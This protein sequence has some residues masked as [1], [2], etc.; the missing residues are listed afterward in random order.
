MNNEFET[1]QNQWK[2]DKGNIESTSNDAEEIFSSI[3][4]KKSWSTRFHYGNILVLSTVLIGI[5]A[6]FY[7]VAPVQELLSRVGVGL[8]VGGLLIRIIIEV[9]SVSKAKKINMVNDALQTTND[10]ITFYN[11]RKTIHGPLTIGIIGLYTIGFYMI[12]PEFSLYFE[13]WKL[14]LIDVSYIIGGII[15]FLAVRKNIKKEIKILLEI[16]QLKKKMTEE[17]V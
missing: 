9:I 4:K 15:P 2:K 5:I 13:T 7:F 8:M 10:T 16:I 17:V 1:L 14:I 11:F 6:F 12:T 3:K